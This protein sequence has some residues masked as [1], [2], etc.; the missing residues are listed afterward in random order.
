MTAKRPSGEH[1]IRYLHDAMRYKPDASPREI[2]R[3]L[4]RR[5][6]ADGFGWL[7]WVAAIIKILLTIA[8][9]LFQRPKS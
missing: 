8:P 2:R 6:K 1:A 3:E 5:L 7:Q 4:R 9:L